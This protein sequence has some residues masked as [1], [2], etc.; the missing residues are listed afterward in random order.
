[1]TVGF[2]IER[3]RSQISAKGIQKPNKFLI[4][5]GIPSGLQTFLTN[6]TYTQVVNNIQYWAEASQ[7]PGIMLQ[8]RQ[9]LRY[10]YGATEKKPFAPT[11][12][13]ISLTIL[14]D[15]KAENWTL[16]QQ[17]IK[18]INN[19]DMRGGLT[20][21]DATTGAIQANTQDVYELSYKNEYAINLDII[22]FN[23]AGTE[24]FHIV[25]REAFPIFVGDIPLNWQDN[26]NLMRIPVS[27]TFSDWYN[28]RT[29]LTIPTQA[30]SVT[31]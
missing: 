23:D 10:G 30:T 16:F 3:F 6:T 31:P 24:T 27:F 9:I 1:M 7:I 26:N 8:M 25:L 20:V 12:N 28:L 13:D 19:Y 29:N 21:L 17:W 5:M 11:F 4:Q 14:A 2:N 18:F 15:G 22:G